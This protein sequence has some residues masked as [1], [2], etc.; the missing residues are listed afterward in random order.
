MGQ[1]GRLTFCRVMMHPLIKASLSSD[2]PPIRA[3]G[4]GFPR[5]TTYARLSF[6]NS[7]LSV[8]AYG[9]LALCFLHDEDF[10]VDKVAMA[11]KIEVPP[12]A[13]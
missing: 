1:P 8:V 13:S 2:P 7:V 11:L 9:V 5:R 3:P 6:L 10:K 12:M 4:P